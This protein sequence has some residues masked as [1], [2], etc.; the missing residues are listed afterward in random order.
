[1]EPFRPQSKRNEKIRGRQLCAQRS[2]TTTTTTITAAAAAEAA[3][4]EH[5]C[6]STLQRATQESQQKPPHSHK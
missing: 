4:G 1:M 5:T 3:T 6:D 2:K